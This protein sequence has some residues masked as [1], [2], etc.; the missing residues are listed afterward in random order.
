MLNSVTRVKKLAYSAL[1]VALIIIGTYIRIPIPLMPFTL[2]MLFVSLAGLMLGPLYSTISIGIYIILGLL[3]LPVFTFGGGFSSVVMPSFGYTIGFLIGVIAEGFI[4]K[5]FKENKLYVYLIASFVFIIIVYTVGIFYFY[6]I[7]TLYLHNNI[8]A[9]TILVNLFLL[10][11]GP[12]II[13]A[14]L[15]S[16]CAYKLNPILLS[17]KIAITDEYDCNAIDM[18][19]DT[20]NDDSTSSANHKD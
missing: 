2:Q 17:S 14:V 13:K 15:A 3:G 11:I 8:S 6:M 7:T 10:L 18:N 1:F 4:I 5:A 9:K 20:D 12:D 16:L 19:Q